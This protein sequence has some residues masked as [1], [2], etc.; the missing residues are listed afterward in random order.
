MKKLRLDLDKLGVHSFETGEV[1]DA[2]GTVA[3]AA[4]DPA[5]PPCETRVFPYCQC[6]VVDPGA[7]PVN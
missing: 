3:A 1:L 6:T 5:R 7:V 4:A 2:R